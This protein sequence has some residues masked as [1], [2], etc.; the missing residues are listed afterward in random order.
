MCGEAATRR[1]TSMC[2]EKTYF[3]VRIFNPHPS[4]NRHDQLSQ[5]YRKQEHVKNKEY[6][7]RIREVKHVSFTPLVVSVTGGMANEETYFYK[8]LASFFARKWDH[9]YSSIMSW[10]RCLL[11]F[12][13]L[14]LAI[15]CIRGVWSSIGHAC[16]SPLSIDL[17]ISESRL[18]DI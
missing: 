15:Q 2:D 16:K 6:E 3:N 8:R 12:S 10:L 5:C 13:L 4:T 7:Q 18:D 11:S 17:V 1:P 9:S 14:C